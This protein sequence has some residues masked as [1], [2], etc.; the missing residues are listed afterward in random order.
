MP[1]MIGLLKTYFKLFEMSYNTEAFENI[2]YH[3]ILNILTA[4]PNHYLG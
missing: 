3:C 1:G 4:G 2:Y